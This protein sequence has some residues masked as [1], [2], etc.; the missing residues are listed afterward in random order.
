MKK[1]IFRIAIVFLCLACFVFTGCHS[2]KK[3]SQKE[4]DKRTKEFEAEHPL[5]EWD[6]LE[7]AEDAV[8][9]TLGEKPELP[10]Y[11]ESY[12]T[13]GDIIQVT[14]SSPEN[15]IRL[16]E[17][18]WDSYPYE[19]I[20]GDFTNYEYGYLAGEGIYQYEIHGLSIDQVIIGS[21]N[22]GLPRNKDALLY[23]IH[24]ENPLPDAEMQNLCKIVLDNI[25]ALDK[26]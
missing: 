17:A 22:N 23:S 25:D 16:R 20:S 26:D 4:I 13:L 15:T 19:N 14:Y 18:K 5:K 11:T 9:L 3:L 2:R 10:G 21:F 8:G 24:S 6:T 7:K 1:N 12:Q